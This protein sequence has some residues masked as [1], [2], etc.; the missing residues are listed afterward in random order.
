MTENKL[1][2][3]ILYKKVY[4]G[5]VEKDGKKYKKYGFNKR[6]S[7]RKIFFISTVIAAIIIEIIIVVNVNQR[8]KDNKVQLNIHKQKES[9]PNSDYG[10]YVPSPPEGGDR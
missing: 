5:I 10:G 8:I 7:G 3:M 2:K 1:L 9:N 4:Q 6:I